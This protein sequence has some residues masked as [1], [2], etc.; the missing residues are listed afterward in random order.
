MN[1]NFS[2]TAGA[3]QS[4]YLP[5]LVGNAIHAVTFKGVEERDIQ[6]VK[7]ASAVYKVLDIK[8]GNAKGYFTHTV[9]EPKQEDFN[10]RKGTN[11]TTGAETTSP[12]N[13]ENMMLLFKHII[14]A[15]NPELGK[16]IDSKEKKISA[17]DWIQ[18]RKLMVAA[19]EKFIGKEV[20]IKLI[21]NKKG[22]TQFPYFSSLTKEAPFT[23]IVMGNFIGDN[24]YFS[25]YEKKQ[26][27]KAAAAT[28]TPAASIE[29]AT[30]GDIGGEIGVESK[31]EFDL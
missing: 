18:L 10:R 30:A 25:A 11:T 21:T 3:A 7:D 8:F 19:T 14:D 1:F 16:Q 27:D 4:S 13:V 12:S 26:I 5:V 23:A 28:P 6:G 29:I 31:V 2:E 17:P 15:V 24:V 22:E 9:W 20:N